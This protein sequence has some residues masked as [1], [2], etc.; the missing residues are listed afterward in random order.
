MLF[1]QDPNR[2]IFFFEHN[3]RGLLSREEKPP[4]WRGLIKT[5]P[6]GQYFDVMIVP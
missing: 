1:D 5:E 6:K 2:T 3:N 4:F